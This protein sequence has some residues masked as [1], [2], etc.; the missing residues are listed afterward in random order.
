M[1]NISSVAVTGLI[2]MINTSISEELISG[3]IEIPPEV[4]L[5]PVGLSETVFLKDKVIPGVSPE[6]L[7]GLLISQSVTIPIVI[8]M[9]V[10]MAGS[11]VI[12]S[13]GLRKRAKP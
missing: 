2:Q 9:M 3:G 10:M 11:T 4:A 13:M 12:S 7:S 6:A 1:D 5:S 8:M